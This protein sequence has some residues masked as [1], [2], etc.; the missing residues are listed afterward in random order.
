LSVV[1]IKTSKIRTMS[2]KRQSSE[3]SSKRRAPAAKPAPVAPVQEEVVKAEVT[4][5]Q[6]PQVAVPAPK[7]R[8]AEASVDA[9]ESSST[10]ESLAPKKAP[11]SK[12]ETK[13]PAAK[14]VKKEGSAKA[15]S[16]ASA[17][18]APA[19]SSSVASSSVAS[20]PAAS[21]SV[22]APKTSEDEDKKDANPCISRYLR[23][24]LKS[25]YADSTVSKD[26]IEQVQKYVFQF[27]LHFLIA[28]KR[29]LESARKTT[30]MMPDM[31][32]CLQRTLSAS[33]LYTEFSNA[34]TTALTHYYASYSNGEVSGDASSA[35]PA[36]PGEVEENRKKMWAARAGLSI[37]PT[38]TKE[39][40]KLYLSK[41]RFSQN[42]I[43][44]LT[45]LLESLALRLFKLSFEK[46]QENGRKRI[47]QIDVQN[48]ASSDSD[49][50]WLLVQ[51]S[52]P[53][54]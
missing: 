19:A 34:M 41:F 45:A 6:A 10:K 30:L 2:S 5:A 52:V 23:L 12:K 37:P 35:A 9:K 48:A 31:P 18:S 42:S 49:L 15:A 38:R 1:C 11:S 26:A 17:A 47:S 43:T 46:A 29:H 24:L 22:E 28:V 16:A 7:K 13:E 51:P 21:S 50:Q 4:E 20:T 14:R 44:G 3:G 39:F 25:V 53:I 27:G 33:S 36:A 54:V 32:I 40:A 8:K